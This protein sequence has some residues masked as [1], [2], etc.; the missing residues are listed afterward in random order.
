MATATATRHPFTTAEW[1]ALRRCERTLHRW[2]EDECN[3]VIQYD[4]NGNNPRRYYSD[5]Y[6]SPTVPGP[7][8]TDKSEAAMKNARKIAAKHGL[9]VY[10]QTDPRGCALY[11][12]SATDLKGRKI[13]ECYSVMALPV[14]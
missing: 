1:T 14:I 11:V 9:S 6:G 8:I 5:R 13:D 12:Y 2:A 4:D 3:G 7:I 10:N